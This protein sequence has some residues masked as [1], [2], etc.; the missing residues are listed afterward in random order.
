MYNDKFTKEEIETVNELKEYL[1]ENLIEVVRAVDNLGVF[2]AVLKDESHYNLL[3]NCLGG[4]ILY[5]VINKDCKFGNI[6]TKYIK[7][8]TFFSIENLLGGKIHKITHEDGGVRAL[9]K[10]GYAFNFEEEL[11]EGEKRFVMFFAIIISHFFKNTPPEQVVEIVKEYFIEKSKEN[12]NHGI[13]EEHVE[14]VNETKKFLE[15]FKKENNIKENIVNNEEFPLHIHNQFC[16]LMDGKITDDFAGIILKY[17]DILFSIQMNLERVNE[18]V[19]FGWSNLFFLKSE[20]NFIVAGDFNSNFNAIV[21]PHTNKTIGLYC[22]DGVMQVA[23]NLKYNTLKSTVF[24]HIWKTAYDVAVNNKKYEPEKLLATVFSY[25]EQKGIVKDKVSI[26]PEYKFK[27]KKINIEGFENKNPAEANN[28]PIESRFFD[29]ILNLKNETQLKENALLLNSMTNV[30]KRE[31]QN[32]TMYFMQTAEYS[33]NRITDMTRLSFNNNSDILFTVDLNKNSFFIQHRKTQEIFNVEDFKDD[34][35]EYSRAIRIK[36]LL[37][38]LADKI[39]M[40]EFVK[41]LIKTI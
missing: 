3:V 38:L 10:D 9:R 41:E 15:R 1:D 29:L 2:N 4:S 25:V 30:I 18:G 31:T 19:P 39:Q 8:N 35:E 32:K 13:D 26:K 17:T 5:T 21:N 11:N 40:R 14:L 27:I 23:P 24:C 28:A 16:D 36:T 22:F 34:K 7:E 33:H 37:L 20:G 6:K 12:L